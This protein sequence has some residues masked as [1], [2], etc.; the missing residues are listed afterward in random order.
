VAS[1]LDYDPT[2]VAIARNTVVHGTGLPKLVLRCGVTAFWGHL[3]RRESA[4][5]A[6][7]GFS[8]AAI[9]FAIVAAV[10]FS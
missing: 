1:G 2:V 8:I 9:G 3:T 5:Y 10:R 7:L 6:A 4:A